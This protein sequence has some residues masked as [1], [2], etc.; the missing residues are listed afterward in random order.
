ME[1]VR[2]Y[3]QYGMYTGN[4]Y[5]NGTAYLRQP[6]RG[7]TNMYPQAGYRSYLNNIRYPAIFGYPL[8]GIGARNTQDTRP[9]H[10]NNGDHSGITNF[11]K[12]P[13]ILIDPLLTRRFSK[14]KREKKEGRPAPYPRLRRDNTPV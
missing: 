10:V 14:P 13:V 9:R 5:A 2:Y 7:A 8:Y 12:A 6:I 1:P 4:P 3:P 11:D